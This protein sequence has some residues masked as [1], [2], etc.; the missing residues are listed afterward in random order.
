METKQWSFYTPF[1]RIVD[2]DPFSDELLDAS[3]E[4]MQ[5]STNA[6]L[7]PGYTVTFYPSVHPQQCDCEVDNSFRFI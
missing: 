4:M 3:A 7:D 5:H 6:R 2:T 1:P